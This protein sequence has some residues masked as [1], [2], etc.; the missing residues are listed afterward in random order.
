MCVLSAGS[1]SRRCFNTARWSCR[2]PVPAPSSAPWRTALP[3]LC[4]PQAA[5]QFRNVEGG[6]RSGAALTLAPD[7]ARPDAIVASVNRL[8]EDHAFR[9][10]AELVAAE[11]AGMPS[12][13]DVVQVL[14][15][16]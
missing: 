6:L 15:D 13:S 8:L 3:Q 11:I 14:T 16:L 10:N 4:L 2:T 9:H 5:D 1:T 7:E 12:P